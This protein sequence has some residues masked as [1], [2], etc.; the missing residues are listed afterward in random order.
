MA[1]CTMTIYY[2]SFL[3]VFLISRYKSTYNKFKTW[4][5]IITQCSWTKTAKIFESKFDA[6]EP[7]ILFKYN[8]DNQYKPNN[9]TNKHLLKT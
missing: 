9:L 6:Q 2:F 4:W 8:S 7:G 1:V 5:D 3:I